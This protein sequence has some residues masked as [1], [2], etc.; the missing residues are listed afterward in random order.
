MGLSTDRNRLI[1]TITVLLSFFEKSTKWPPF[2]LRETIQRIG[3]GGG[4]GNAA[5]SRAIFLVPRLI[6]GIKLCFWAV[7]LGWSSWFL[8]PFR[9]YKC[10]LGS[11]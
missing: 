2:F 6:F 1:V 5:F 11:L 4:V 9:I 8:V 10:H 7:S 3:G